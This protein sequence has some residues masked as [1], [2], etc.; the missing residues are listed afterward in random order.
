MTTYSEAGVDISTGDK[1]SKIAYTAAKSTFSGREGR[2]GAP[3]ILEGGFAGMLDFGDFYLVQN[4]DG[5]GTKMMVAEQI[6]K[7]DTLGYDLLAMVVDDAVCLGA[8]VVSITNT[9]DCHKV[10]SAVIEVL[11]GG[12]A[13]ACQEQHVVIPGGEIAE[14]NQMVNGYTWNAAAVGIVAK[15]RVITGTKIKVGDKV[16]GLPAV[17]FRSNGFSLVRHVLQKAFGDN[18]HNTAYMNGQTWGE[19]VLKPSRIYHNQ[20]LELLGRYGEP[21][22]VDVAGIVHITGGGLQGNISR[23]L[24]EGLGMQLDNLIEPLPIM[25]KL[26]QLGSIARDEAYKTWNMGIAMVV[27]VDPS[28]EVKVLAHFPDAQTM[29]VIDNSGE[30]KF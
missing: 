16:I 19:A 12:L 22:Q 5:V 26:I 28:A 25:Q 8:E 24:P 2:M 23:I 9:V 4:D 13:K 1:A 6:G 30:I 11:M 18:W 14:L 21:R 7:Y 15:D 3:A 10:D 27:I 20:L 17:G 29:G